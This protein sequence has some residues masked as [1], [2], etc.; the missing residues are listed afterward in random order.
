MADL[1]GLGPCSTMM[2]QLNP[3]MDEERVRQDE[4]ATWS[5]GYQILT[6]FLERSQH[7]TFKKKSR[8]VE[9]LQVDELV[10]Q[11]IAVEPIGN[12]C[13]L[14]IWQTQEQMAQNPDAQSRRR[15]GVVEEYPVR[16][17]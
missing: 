10:G 11:I 9:D 14:V 16:G 3:A 13:V 12:H 7:A 15:R 6:A 5:F 4:T 2:L 1:R 8:V 17:E